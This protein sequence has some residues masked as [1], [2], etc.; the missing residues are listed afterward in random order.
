MAWT[1]KELQEGGAMSRKVVPVVI[2]VVLAC[3]A[4]PIIGIVMYGGVAAALGGLGIIAMLIA[5]Q[6][7]LMRVLV[8][9]KK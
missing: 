6:Y 8:R 4:M 9:R 2:A 7:P 5:I 3:F 1:I